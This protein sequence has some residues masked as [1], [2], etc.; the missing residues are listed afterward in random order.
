MTLTFG[1]LSVCY[2]YIILTRKKT[3]SYPQLIFIG[4]SAIII[5]TIK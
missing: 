1:L 5:G 2:Y 4:K 3:E